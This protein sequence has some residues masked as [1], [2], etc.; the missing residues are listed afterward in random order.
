MGSEEV[1]NAILFPKIKQ[2]SL[3]ILLQYL[4][5]W[6]TESAFRV[7][8]MET[9]QFSWWTMMSYK[10]KTNCLSYY[11]FSRLFYNLCCS[12]SGNSAA[13]EVRDTGTIL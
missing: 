1:R 5:K 9:E 4:M 12:L 11:I 10:Y 13:D 7:K 2:C 6:A 3:S 8:T